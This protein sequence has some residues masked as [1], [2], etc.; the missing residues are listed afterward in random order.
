MMESEWNNVCVLVS[1]C[2]IDKEVLS[3]ESGGFCCYA[4][5]SLDFT[6][7]C[8]PVFLLLVCIQRKISI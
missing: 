6:V 4:D 7:I 3:L 2:F 1:E 5:G 8:F